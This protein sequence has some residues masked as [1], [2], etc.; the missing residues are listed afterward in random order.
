[1]P[2][3]YNQGCSF[4][5]LTL[6]KTLYKLSYVCI[7]VNSEYMSLSRVQHVD[8]YL[9]KHINMYFLKII[10]GSKSENEHYFWL[11][12]VIHYGTLQTYQVIFIIRWLFRCYWWYFWI[13]IW[14]IR[15]RRLTKK[16]WPCVSTVSHVIRKKIAGDGSFPTFLLLLCSWNMYKHS[17]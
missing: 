9:P 11:N 13:F 8:K 12:D 16:G 14:F 5:L 4:P 10:L 1:M 17:G 3:N 6:Y 7:C 15:R 2:L